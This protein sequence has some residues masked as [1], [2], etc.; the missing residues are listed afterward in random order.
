MAIGVYKNIPKT[1]ITSQRYTSE[2]KPYNL[3]HNEELVVDMKF[4]GQNQSSGSEVNSQGWERDSKYYFE[5][6]SKK[7]PEYFSE[8]NK[9]YIENGKTPVVDAKFVKHFP[10]YKGYENETLVHHH[11]GGDGQAVAVPKSMHKGF[12]EIHNVEKKAGITKNGQEFSKECEK[13]CERNPEGVG[14][15]AKQLKTDMYKEKAKANQEV[16]ENKPKNKYSRSR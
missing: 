13:Y 15:T 1:E 16:E 11:V 12:G 9:K 6:L 4:R 14:K 8:K 3:D 5:E 7:H 2:G 10:E